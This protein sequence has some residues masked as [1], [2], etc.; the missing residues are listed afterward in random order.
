MTPPEISADLRR[1]AL[2]TPSLKGGE[3]EDEPY[4]LITEFVQGETVVTLAAFATG[5]ASLYFSTAGGIIGGI[6]KPAVGELARTTVASLGPLVPQLQRSDAIEPP[7][8]GEFC[9]YLLTPGG[10]RVCRL[11][12]SGTARADGPEVKLIRLSGALLTKVRESAS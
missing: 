11:H 5:D 4:A 1:R 7:Q 12:A 10:R 3:V 6:G 2:D 8:P 9:F